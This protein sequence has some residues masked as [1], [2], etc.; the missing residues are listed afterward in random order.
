MQARKATNIVVSQF[1]TWMSDS[2]EKG[3]VFAFYITPYFSSSSILRIRITAIPPSQS[4]K[5]SNISRCFSSSFY[6]LLSDNPVDL[7]DG[8]H[9][10][11]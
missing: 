5:S 11:E 3:D 4:A 10:Q 7:P 2:A 1:C 9:L 8:F 6:F